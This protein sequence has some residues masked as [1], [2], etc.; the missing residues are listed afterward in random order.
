MM[1]CWSGKRERGG[2]LSR[3]RN[4]DFFIGFSVFICSHSR[5]L[6]RFALLDIDNLDP[7]W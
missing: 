4:I 5:F 1:H 2:K 7:V 6:F 3:W